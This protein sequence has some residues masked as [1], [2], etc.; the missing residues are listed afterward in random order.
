MG[1]IE[2]ISKVIIYDK[3]DTISYIAKLKKL[4]VILYEYVD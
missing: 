4:K 3:I 2:R 1:E